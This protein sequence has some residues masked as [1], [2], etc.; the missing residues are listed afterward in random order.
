MTVIIKR[1]DL[2]GISEQDFAACVKIHADNLKAWT[3]QMEKIEQKVPGFDPYPPPHTHP[4][5][6]SVVRRPDFVAD[7]KIVDEEEQT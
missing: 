2:Q 6:N 1:P 7:Y 4:L 3:A 5:V